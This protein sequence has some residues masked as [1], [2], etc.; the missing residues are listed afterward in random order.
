[1]SSSS[2][3]RMEYLRA[4]AVSS[5][6]P[7]RFRLNV[8]PP[9]LLGLVGG[10]LALVLLL[11][12]P[13]PWNISLPLYLVLFFWTLL[14]PRVALYL[15]PIA[16]P[17]G[18]LQYID[19]GELRLN[20]ADLLVVFLA[21]GWLLSFTLPWVK[22]RGRVSAV[23]NDARGPTDR[24][25]SN[26]PSYL[27]V[28]MLALL[29]I[30]FLSMIVATSVSTSLKEISKWSEFLVLILLGAQYIRTRRQIWII[31][32]LICLAG[33]TQ[34]VYGYYQEFFNLGPANF[35][36]DASLRV[37]GTFDQPNP[38]AGYINIPLSIALALALLGRGWK[39]RILSGLAALL[40][41]VAEFLSQSK[42]GYSAI[43][44]ALLFIV[45][46]G[47]LR[48]RPVM[49]LLGIGTLGF[50]GAAFAG[51]VPAKLYTPVLE[52]IGVI[53]ISFTAPSSQDYAN[54]E[55]LAHWIAGLRMFFDH[56]FLGVGI[57][58]YPNA[59]PQYYITIFVNS[60]GH[61]HNYYINIAAETGFIGL[62]V[63]L[64]F[65]G[66]IFVAGGS[67]YRGI[68]R[69]Y[70]QERISHKIE[71]PL[72]TLNKLYALLGNSVGFDVRTALT[73]DRALALGLLAALLSVC[74]HNLVDDLY[75]HSMTNLI[76]LLII[77][78]IRLER[79]T[80]EVGS[81]TE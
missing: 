37:Y 38:Y 70:V 73:N 17:W 31:V 35:I 11:G 63:Y 22:F 39:T 18:S 19:V 45:V 75:V 47:M 44:V 69:K 71:A 55:R 43:A 33:I 81:N 10:G 59:Y 7:T 76:A 34:A 78:L 32:V 67:A 41:G 56:P 14:Q 21:L 36:R 16:I 52:K 65:L 51:W 12:L 77:A 62:V 29:G 61:A 6:V 46:V 4:G 42:G 24:E 5:T 53:N 48:F 79:V 54:A 64:F 23:S 40:L 20:S 8:S 26:V 49:G 30:M 15:L 1:M 25:I 9:T 66:A 2:A 74:V 13:E 57:G 50:L 3:S 60:L 28:A 72:G 58:N 80:P 27:V 68:N